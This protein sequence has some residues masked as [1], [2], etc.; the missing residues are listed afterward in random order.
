MTTQAAESQSDHA[1]VVR[2]EIVVD[3]PPERAFEVFTAEMG[4]WWPPDHHVLPA[5]LA[6]MVF[7]PRAGGHIIDRAVD[8]SEC[9]WGRVLAYDPP[10]RVVFSWDI[11]LRWQIEPDP[12][13]TSEVEVRFIE[14]GS[15][16]TRVTLEHRHLERH[17]EGWER[18]QAAVESPGGWPRGLEAL[19]AEIARG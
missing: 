5:E 12:A 7:E 19:A 6:E 2:T 15:D 9:R 16:Q 3:A 18:M 14:H 10:E 13:K 8:G 17:G 4:S 1:R 11:S